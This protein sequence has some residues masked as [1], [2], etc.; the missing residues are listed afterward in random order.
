MGI[1]ESLLHHCAAAYPASITIFLC[2][3]EMRFPIAPPC[4]AKIELDGLFTFTYFTIFSLLHTN[5]F[6]GK[7]ELVVNDR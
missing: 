1:I 2:I 4:A 5:F 3:H 6:P 7:V